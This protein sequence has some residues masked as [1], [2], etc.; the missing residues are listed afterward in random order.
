MTGAPRATQSYYARLA[1]AVDRIHAAVLLTAHVCDLLLLP[2]WHD[3]FACRQLAA[4][5]L[6]GCCGELSDSHFVVR[7]QG[8]KITHR[9][10]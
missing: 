2:A 5:A 10:Q 8:L 6:R 3:S 7:C 1:A 4:L 9:K